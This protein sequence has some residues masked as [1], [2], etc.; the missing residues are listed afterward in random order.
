M[1][2]DLVKRV[3]QYL[4]KIQ[5]YVSFL[6]L[7]LNEDM[8]DDFDRAYLGFFKEFENFIW[9]AYYQED[10]HLKRLIESYEEFIHP[11]D[12]SMLFYCLD[13]IKHHVDALSFYHEGSQ[14]ERKRIFEKYLHDRFHEQNTEYLDDFNDEQWDLFE[15]YLFQAKSLEELHDYIQALK[16]QKK[17]Q[18]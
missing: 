11:L 4:E 14:A 10:S 7:Y 13:G 16:E 8:Y 18:V 3:I 5:D 15:E 9:A 2:I 17:I 1:E 12:Q 6:L